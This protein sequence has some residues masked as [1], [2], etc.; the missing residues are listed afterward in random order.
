MRGIQVRVVVFFKIIPTHELSPGALLTYGSTLCVVSSRELPSKA[1][2][3]L[4]GGSF[5]AGRLRVC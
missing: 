2:R 1:Q 5:L 3:G 4:R